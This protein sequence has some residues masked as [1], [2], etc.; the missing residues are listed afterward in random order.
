MTSADPALST[1]WL[2]S[3]IPLVMVLLLST[4]QF[5]GYEKLTSPSCHCLGEVTSA[6][7]SR[8]NPRML[9]HPTQATNPM[10]MAHNSAT[11][12]TTFSDFTATRVLPSPKGGLALLFLFS[13]PLRVRGRKKKK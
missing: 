2:R 6:T 1:W 3:S 8:K 5:D 7:G 4:S 10:G 13:T 9:S 12:A 11:T